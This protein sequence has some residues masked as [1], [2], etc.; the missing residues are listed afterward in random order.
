MSK[1]E[2]NFP[3]KYNSKK[4]LFKRFDI[5]SSSLLNAGVIFFGLTINMVWEDENGR[6]AIP[7]YDELTAKTYIS[8]FLNS[9]C[10]IDFIHCSFGSV[11]IGKAGIPHIH[12]V[13][14]FR[15]PENIMPFIRQKIESRL[16]ECYMSDYKISYLSKFIDVTRSLRYLSKDFN[17]ERPLNICFSCTYS[18]VHVDIACVFGD[19]IDGTISYL[20]DKTDVW[21]FGPCFHE[22][23]GLQYVPFGCHSEFSG[24]PSSLQKDKNAEI[25]YYLMLFFSLRGFFI[26][27]GSLY[28]KIE[29]SLNSYTYLGPSEIIKSRFTHFMNDLKENTFD[30]IDPLAL[31]LKFF[32]NSDKVVES[33][34]LACSNS[35]RTLNL[36]VL[37][38]KDGLYLAYNDTFI[39]RSNKIEI[40]SLSKKFFFTRHYSYYYKTYL[41]NKTAGPKLWQSKLLQN[42]SKRDFIFFS[43]IFRNIL[44]SSEEQTKKN[45]LFLTGVSNSGKS[46][47][48]L[49]I[50]KLS[51]GV[52]NTGSLS[53]D[54]KFLFE[55][56]I[57]KALAI[58]DEADFSE[59]LIN[60]LKK[61]GSGETLTVNT[62]FEKATFEGLTT[63]ILAASNFS[64]NIK[65]F[66]KDEAIKNRIYHFIF[67]EECFITD[68]ESKQI[69][70]EIP[71]ILLFCNKLYFTILKKSKEGEVLSPEVSRFFL[72]E[73][74]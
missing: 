16:Y 19:Y 10:D 45:I 7:V 20:S 56:L 48:V 14:G 38:F 47:L 42:L 46:R 2:L 61:F 59:K 12:C 73:K 51:T 60:Q 43:L 31:S 63:K 29:G 53:P 17:K 28:Q 52:E 49:D 34:S 23:G 24:L 70:L 36:E 18:Y 3:L 72:E 55:N 41:R 68:K 74:K 64:D 1:K 35:N 62:K 9:L 6:M 15:I 25:V 66:L 21:F 44:F 32:N 37:E 39:D 33:L 26:F 67:N 22:G 4:D 40:D 5:W 27:K 57:D 8:R 13:V 65:A 58:I 50:A 11:E 54:S 69:V 30:F 71:K